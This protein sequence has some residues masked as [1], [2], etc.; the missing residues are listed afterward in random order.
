[1]PYFLPI[2][3]LLIT[4]FLFIAC[5]WI[6]PWFYLSHNFT[7]SLFSLIP[8]FHLFPI[9]TYSLFSLIPN[10]FTNSLNLTY[11]L[12]LAYSLILNY[13]LFLLIAYFSYSQ[14]LTNSLF[15]PIPNSFAYS[16][17]YSLFPILYLLP[18]LPYISIFSRFPFF[19]LFH[20]FSLILP[21][22]SD[23][24]SPA[25]FTY[26]AHA[27]S[28]GLALQSGELGL[29]YF[30]GLQKS[31]SKCNVKQHEQLDGSLH[32]ILYEKPGAILKLDLIKC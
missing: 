4:C 20:L 24:N 1:M 25:K 12:P 28:G 29:N 10:S 3:F 8:N 23:E 27:P 17:L 9:F 2:P 6:V 7:Y 30:L 13:S 22:F 11:F 14:F 18:L 15:L 32:L 21:I 26:L 19:S 31:L 5:I 16:P